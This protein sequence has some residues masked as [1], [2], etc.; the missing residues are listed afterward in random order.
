MESEEKFIPGNEPGEHALIW[1]TDKT[2]MKVT[3]AGWLADWH[4]VKHM[5]CRIYIY[6]AGVVI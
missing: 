1:Q 5:I 6:R 2:E 4:Q 3:G